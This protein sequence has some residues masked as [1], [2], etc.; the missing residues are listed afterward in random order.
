MRSYLSEDIFVPQRTAAVTSVKELSLY[1]NEMLGCCTDDAESVLLALASLADFTFEEFFLVFPIYNNSIPNAVNRLV[2]RGYFKASPFPRFDGMS[3]KYFRITS[4]G[5]Q[6]ANS[7]FL[8]TV[9]VRYKYGYQE[10]SA[11]HRYSVGLNLYA[12]LSFG[13]PFLWKKEVL[14]GTG[15]GMPQKGALQADACVG[16]YEGTDKERQFYIEQD[17]GFE[18][19][20]Q[21]YGKLERYAAYGVMGNPQDAVLFSFRYKGISVTKPSRAGTLYSRTRVNAI[22]ARMKEHGVADAGQLLELY[23]D[24]A[25]LQEFLVLCGAAERKKDGIMRKPGITI[26][27]AF[28][29]E[30]LFSLKF[31]V[32]GYVLRDLNQKQSR[33][34]RSRLAQF[35]ALFYGWMD[36]GQ[37]QGVSRQMLQGFP[38]YFMTT[39]LLCSYGEILMP[40]ELGLP[41]KMERTLYDCYG[42]LGSYQMTT[43]ALPLQNGYSLCLRN[44]FPYTIAGK[45]HGL[46]CVEFL[47]TDLSAWVRLRMFWSYYEGELPVHVIAVLDDQKQV[48]DLYTYLGCYYP[49]IA[50]VLDRKAVLS[51]MY[52]DLGK[53]G[54]LFTLSDPFGGGARLYHGGSCTYKDLN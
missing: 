16:I 28:L 18:R 17:M 10:N 15:R 12:F 35:V 50:V 13:Q 2:K 9:P 43:P 27:E 33:L 26:G 49:E 7:F 4:A 31:H 38:V 53:S 24:D 3:K 52:G 45:G 6:A 14:L 30:F 8:G 32:N 37:L 11:A 51:C 42:K 46:V 25:F 5:H 36:K 54:R 29:K 23:P 21:L 44:A 20:S 39:S 47:N 19:D 41:D 34:A 48:S 40:E 1:I 22:L